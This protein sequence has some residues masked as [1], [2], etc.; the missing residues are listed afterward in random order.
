V[1]DLATRSLIEPGPPA[2][3]PVL[4]ARYAFPPNQHGYC[5]PEDADGFFSSGVAGDD[6][7][8][9]ALVRAFDGAWPFLKLI[10]DAGSGVDALDPDVV[11]SYWLGGPALE[12]VGPAALANR[13]GAAS[14]PLFGSLDEAVRAGAV[15]HHSF[16]VFCVYPWVAML[17]DVRRTPQALRVLDG[18]RIRWGRVT[19]VDGDTLTAE[20]RPLSW[21]GQRLGYGPPVAETVRRSIDGR[22][23]ASPVDV[24]D[25]VALHWDWVCDRISDEQE[26]QLELYSA[27][28]LAL[29]NQVLASR[30]VG[31]G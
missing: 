2:S 27:R 17:G 14:G 5:G 11:E 24:G 16:V 4:F 21:D 20:S 19:E 9:R 18:C 29:V 3:G 31:R 22:R 13:S 10:A 8:L 23:L 7:D 15:P 1:S 25:R 30:G 28:H 26:H 12:R 6:A